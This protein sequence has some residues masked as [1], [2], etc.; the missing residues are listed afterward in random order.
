MLTLADDVNEAEKLK[1]LETLLQYDVHDQLRLGK[2][3]PPE[4]W[5]LLKIAEVAN[6]DVETFKY[7]IKNNFCINACAERNICLIQNFVDRYKSEDMKQNVM[8]LACNRKKL[9]KDLNNE[10]TPA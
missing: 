5:I 10:Q 9:K 4:S 8:L 2:P 1:M 6:R 3:G 7:L